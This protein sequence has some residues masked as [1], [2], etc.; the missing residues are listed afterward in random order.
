MRFDLVNYL[1]N[2]IGS[3]YQWGGEGPSSI[4]FDCSGLVLEGLRSIG[5][6]GIRDATSQGIYDELIKTYPGISSNLKDV[7]CLV[8]FG[9]DTKSIT[10]IGIGIN[11]YQYIEA[12]GGGSKTVDVGMVR[13]RPYTWRR[14]LVAVVDIFDEKKLAYENVLQMRSA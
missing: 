11:N 10:H 12:G 6:W 5:K 14:D 2:F 9:K 8:F 4:G 13:I 1:F 7:G 3:R